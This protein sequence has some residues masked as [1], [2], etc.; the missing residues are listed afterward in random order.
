MTRVESVEKI[1]RD[2][3]AVDCTQAEFRT[4]ETALYQVLHRTAVN[5]P[6]K[7]VQQAEGTE[8][9]LRFGI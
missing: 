1:D 6:L 2:T 3:L 4:F 5:E 9:I 8:R 7:M